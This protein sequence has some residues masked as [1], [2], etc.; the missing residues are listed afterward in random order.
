MV[1]LSAVGDI[2]LGDR[3]LMV[4]LGVGSR[5]QADNQYDPFKAVKDIFR[6]SDMVFGNLECVL[7][8]TGLDNSRIESRIM[9]AAPESVRLLENGCFSL[10]SVANN[11]IMQQGSACFSDTVT[12]LLDQG[13]APVGVAGRDMHCIPAFRVCGGIRFGFLGYCLRPEKYAETPLYAR[14]GVLQILDEIEA[15]GRRCRFVIVSLHWGDEY[16]DC[17]AS[18]Q[19]QAARA[20]IDRGA[21]AVLGHHPHVCQGVENYKGGV[22]AYS[23]GNFVFDVWQRRLRESMVL[24]LDFSGRRLESVVRQPVYIA[25]DFRPGLPPLQKMRSF[26]RRFSLLDQKLR[27][28]P[29]Q[30]AFSGKA[31]Q[32]KVWLAERINQ[33]QNR[34]IFLLQ[35]PRYQKDVILQSLSG[36]FRSRLEG[37][38]K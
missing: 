38:N 3:A 15:V 37:K 7:S 27:R 6:S 14:A 8:D 4:G 16:V 34:L 31:Y 20:M 30:L 23:L 26:Q 24:K 10:L 19:I 17:P 2:N 13:I 18:W 22:I 29:G 5:I 36:F 33:L 9:R 35:L 21:S 32:R 25:S 11:H 12:T 1:T 28:D